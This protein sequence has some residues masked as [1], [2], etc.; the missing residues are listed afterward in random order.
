[1][2]DPKTVSSFGDFLTMSDQEFLAFKRMPN[3]RHVFDA[4]LEATT[5]ELS[6]A[7][8]AKLIEVSKEDLRGLLHS[9]CGEGVLE[10]RHVPDEEPLYR[11]ADIEDVQTSF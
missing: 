7:D 6:S 2:T 4:F 10:V 1:M 9:L 5:D 11:L 8:L 3:A